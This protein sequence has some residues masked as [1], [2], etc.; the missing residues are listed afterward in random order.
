MGGRRPF[1][2]TEQPT[3]GLVSEKNE[4]KTNSQKERARRKGRREEKGGL[5]HNV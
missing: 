2:R 3:T 5:A 4:T 1:W